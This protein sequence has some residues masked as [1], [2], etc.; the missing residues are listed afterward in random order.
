MESKKIVAILDWVIRA[1][2]ILLLG[3]CFWLWLGPQPEVIMVLQGEHKTNLMLSLERGGTPQIPVKAWM[4]KLHVDTIVLKD[5]SV[6]EIKTCL[7]LRRRLYIACKDEES[8]MA[9]KAS[10]WDAKCYSNKFSFS[11][12]TWE[13]GMAWGKDKIIIF[14]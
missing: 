7:K 1:L 8:E 2:W 11:H 14:Y 9:L 5:P 6:R 12:A 10:L 4:R 3:T 13:P